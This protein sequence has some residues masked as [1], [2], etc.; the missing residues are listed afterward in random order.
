MKE[1]GKGHL[2]IQI[3]MATNLKDNGSKFYTNV[4]L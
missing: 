1:K 2:K 4:I 3:I